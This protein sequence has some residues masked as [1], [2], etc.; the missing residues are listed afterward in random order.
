M[1]L[2]SDQLKQRTMS[3]ALNVLRFIDKIPT[4][5]SG[6]VISRQLAKSATSV[7][8]N[9]RACC[10]A[11]SRV[12]FIAKLGV[13]VEEVDESVYWL[14]LMT[15]AQLLSSSEVFPVRGEAAELRAIFAKSLGTARANLKTG[16]SNEQIK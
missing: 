4:T 14:D 12:E 11:R 13:V 7:G 8:A 15:G 6:Q 5:F 10:N 16:K 9:Y 2:Q 3:F 1:S